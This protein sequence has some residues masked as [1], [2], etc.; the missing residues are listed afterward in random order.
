[1]GQGRE[2]K[3]ATREQVSNFTVKDGLVEL[4]SDDFDVR[5]LVVC[6]EILKQTRFVRA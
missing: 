3:W 6:A 1:M 4:I 2:E 5:V